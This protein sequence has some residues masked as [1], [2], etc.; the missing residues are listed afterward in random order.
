MILLNDKVI[1]ALVCGLRAQQIKFTQIPH[2]VGF[3][4]NVTIGVVKTMEECG[5]HVLRNKKAACV[6]LTRD[7]GF[8]CVIPDKIEMFREKEE[9]SQTRAFLLDARGLEQCEYTPNL[10]GIFACVLGNDVILVFIK[11]PDGQKVISG[12]TDCCAARKRANGTEVCCPANTFSG[13]YDNGTEAIN[14]PETVSAL[15]K[16][17]TDVNA[18]PVKIENDAQNSA[19]MCYGRIYAFLGIARSSSTTVPV[20]DY[21]RR[22]ATPE[23][24]KISH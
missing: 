16:V 10:D 12:A 21:D 1:Q 2:N 5:R 19:L 6:L 20:T 22:N 24:M 15:K 4:K 11:C 8:E 7:D 13:K 23:H 3:S 14:P 9:G 18:L 17:C